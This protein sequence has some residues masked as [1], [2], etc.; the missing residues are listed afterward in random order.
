MPGRTAESLPVLQ[1]AIT[2][3]ERLLGLEGEDE[4]TQA[5]RT[6]TELREGHLP[7]AVRR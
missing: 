6:R 2:Q 7:G 1:E 3:T 4:Q 5:R